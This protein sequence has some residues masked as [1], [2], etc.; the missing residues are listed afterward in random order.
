MNKLKNI[1]LN[2]YINYLFVLYAFLL[3]ISRAGISILTISL[4]ILWLF[5]KDFKSKIEFI[6]SNKVILY[7]LAFI[8]FSLLSLFWSNDVISGLE[9]VRKYWYF[10]VVLVIATTIQKRFV[11]YGISAFLTGLFI[12]EI[13]SY[14]IFFELIQWKNV[15]PNDPTPFMNHLQY[16][17]F[18]AFASLLLLNRFF[19]E[20]KMKW[21]VIYFLYF[22]IITS[23]LFLNGGRTGQAAFAVS[24]F[25]VGF[26]NVKNKIIALLSMF[27]LVLSI[28][29][30]AYHVSPVFKTRFDTSINEIHKISQG[31]FCTSFGARLGL[32]IIGGEIFLENPIIG[33]GVVKDMNDFVKIVEESYPNKD[34]IKHLPSYHNFYVQTAVHLGIIGLFLYLMIFYNLLKLKIQDRYYFT[35][36]VIF[37]SV[38]SVSSLVENMFHEQFSAALLA[39]FSGIFIAQN[40]IENEV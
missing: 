30:T 12:S 8:G 33:T 19:Y 31:S 2:E 15:S 38:Y 24:I 23:N 25:V 27:A 35:L 1:T 10:L 9:Y 32:W 37:V 26:L 29:Y 4:F 11:E 18:L 36:M 21:K 7:F 16:S 6:K 3:P 14:S 22:L 5:T 40:R 13:L 17:M 28:F 34:C 20:N 39:L